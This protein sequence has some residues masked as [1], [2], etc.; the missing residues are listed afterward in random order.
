MTMANVSSQA[1]KRPERMSAS[2]STNGEALKSTLNVMKAVILRDIKS[3]YFNHGLGFLIVPMMPVAHMAILLAIYTFTGRQAIFGESMMLFFAT[4]LVPALA[5]SY[6]S[7]FMSVSLI[8]NKNMLAFP[9]IKLLDI[10]LARSILEFVGVVISVGF[11]AVIF[12]YLG[13]DVTPNNPLQAFEALLVTVALSIG[14][15]IIVSVVSLAA[16]IFAVIYSLSTVLIYLSSGAPIYLQ[17]FPSV[18]VYICSYNPVF[19]SVEWMRSAYYAGYPSDY[20]DKQ[21]LL[22]WT[23]C[24][25]AFGLI[26]ER[27]GKRF[28]LTW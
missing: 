10:I 15:G 13:V 19:H 7:R 14:V 5:F 16:P 17:A 4:G 20:F 8:A 21:Y 12:L 28:F 11:I 9:A 2:R 18:V 23:M 26:L 27:F 3:R 1:A 24:S 6:I 22:M 25:A